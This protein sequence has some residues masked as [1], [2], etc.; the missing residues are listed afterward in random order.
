MS[1]P[2][3]KAR[4]F[5]WFW[6]LILL[7]I[8]AGGI[9]YAVYGL[10]EWAA[11]GSPVSRW[12]KAGPDDRKAVAQKLIT[13]GYLIGKSREAVLQDLGPPDQSNEAQGSY[14]WKVGFETKPGQDE[15]DRPTM[16][17]ETSYLTVRFMDGVA[18]VATITAYVT[19]HK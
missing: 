2:A 5:P 15:N 19:K 12:K 1:V 10:P 7:L 18:T 6:V 13:S 14:E 16:I 8:A 3:R 11:I 17:D 9:G 4:K